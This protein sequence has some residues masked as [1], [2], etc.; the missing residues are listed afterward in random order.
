MCCKFVNE[1]GLEQNRAPA[2]QDCI[3]MHD[4]PTERFS[5][6]GRYKLIVRPIKGPPG[7]WNTLSIEVRRT[8][9]GVLVGT[10]DR[11][12]SSDQVLHFLQQ[13]GV[14]YLILSEN[15]HGGYGA[16]NLATGEKALY[17]PRDHTPDKTTP[18]WCW[19]APVSHDPAQRQLVISGCYWACPYDRVTFD[20]S[21]PMNPPYPILKMEDEPWE[22]DAED[23]TESTS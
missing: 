14:D 12:H 13:D 3:A 1:G 5:P 22:E 19:A 21:Q 16:M 4:Q 8:E 7:T 2:A 11:N 6:D 9:D 18:F 10:T 23:D 15:Y 20:F 17:N